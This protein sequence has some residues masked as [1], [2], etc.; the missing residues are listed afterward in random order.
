MKNLKVGNGRRSASFGGMERL[1]TIFQ[2][3]DFRQK[4]VSALKLGFRFE[5]TELKESK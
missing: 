5:K 3:F 2:N 1:K 4:K